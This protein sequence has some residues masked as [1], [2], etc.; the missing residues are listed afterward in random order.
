M[1]YVF[2]LL[3]LS[4]LQYLALCE[5]QRALIHIEGG[6]GRYIIERPAKDLSRTD[7][8]SVIPPI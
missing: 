2:N 1:N 6:L 5:R 7:N 3:P 4:A 8:K